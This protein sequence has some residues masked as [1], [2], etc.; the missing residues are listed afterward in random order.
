MESGRTIQCEATQ[1][2]VVRS[3]VRPRP[4]LNAINWSD[5]YCSI[6]LVASVKRPKMQKAVKSE[7]N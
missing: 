2:C 7:S 4:Q 1:I 5:F 6:D 3:N